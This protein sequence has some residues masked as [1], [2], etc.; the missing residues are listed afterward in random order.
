M[1][2]DHDYLQLVNDEYNVRAWMVQAKQEK[3]DELYEKILRPLRPDEKR[4]EPS[5]EDV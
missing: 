3:A 4:R 2:K 1:T 5:G